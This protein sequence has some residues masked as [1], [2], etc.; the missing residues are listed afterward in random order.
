MAEEKNK[1]APE[2]P[3]FTVVDRRLFTP[4]GEL[5]DEYRHQPARAPAPDTPL[6]GDKGSAGAAA[7]QQTAREKASDAAR[8]EFSRQAAPRDYKADFSQL[9]VSFA[10]TAMYQLGLVR[11]PQGGAP[12]VDLDA[13][14]HTIDMLGVIEEKT[15]GNLTPEEQRI[16]E[17]SL[18]DLRMSY[19]AIMKTIQ[20]KGKRK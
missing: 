4:E 7:A 13:A 14:R 19:L 15:R 12:P 1:H 16:L 3:G 20:E 8:R 6:P 9:I 17:D 5:R 11:D 2:D 10:T 18:Y